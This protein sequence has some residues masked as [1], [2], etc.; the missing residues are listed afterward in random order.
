VTRTLSHLHAEL[1][2]RLTQFFDGGPAADATPLEIRERVLDDVERHVARAGRGRRI[3]PY[4]RI[5]VQV[6]A[7]DVDRPTVTAVFDDIGARVRER[8]RE[9]RC[10]PPLNLEARVTVIDNV[11]AEWTPG[12]RYA[13]EYQRCAETPTAPVAAAAQPSLVVIVLKGAAAQ[14]EFAFSQRTI[15]IGRTPEAT[16]HLGRTRRNDIAFLD[17][18]DGT[19]ETVG[20]AHARI[21]YDDATNAY[22]LF[23]DGSHNGTFVVR[24]GT[25]IPVVARDPR[26]LRLEDGDELHFGRAV[27]GVRTLPSTM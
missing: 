27:V 21:A 1:Q 5:V 4:N 14:A 9:M 25:T 13:I 8:L 18:A 15:A 12:R 10:D 6:V 2:T 20:R 3:F 16:D 23:D 22:L 19:T 11:P 24:R 26:G 17:S 7:L